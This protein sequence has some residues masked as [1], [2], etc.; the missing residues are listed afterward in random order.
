MRTGLAAMRFG[1]VAYIIPFLFVL[2]PTLIMVGDARDIFLNVVTASF[3]VYVVSV[4]TVGYYC[5]RLSVMRRCAI[6]LA[7]IAS[8]VP[9]TVLG[10]G[11]WVD[12]GGIVASVILLGSEHLRQRHLRS[13]IGNRG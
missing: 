8:L 13:A 7:G 3:G 1:W 4:A 2:S 5:R 11:G 9:D 10:A 6:G 12:L